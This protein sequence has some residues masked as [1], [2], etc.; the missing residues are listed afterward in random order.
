MT[1]EEIKNLSYEE[2]WAIKRKN[3]NPDI[4]GS[5]YKR[6]SEEIEYRNTINKIEKDEKPSKK[7]IFWKLII[8]G[9]WEKF[10]DCIF[11]PQ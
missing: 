6:V 1:D 7:I 4:P 8:D 11:K 10:F 5:L 2:L 9:F 3:E